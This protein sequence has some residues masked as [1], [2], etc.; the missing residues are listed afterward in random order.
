GL[1]GAESGG[2]TGPLR[3]RMGLHTCEAE[4]RDGDYYG[5]AV[6]RA[7]RLMSAAHGSQVIVSLVAVEPLR[8][9]GAYDF[10]PADLGEIRLRDLA[11]P[12]RVFQLVAPDLEREFPPLRSLD[13]FATNLPTFLSS[14]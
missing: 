9:A 2:A 3:V 8:D 5:S 14:F 10:D 11:R 12:E 1:L 6:N 7:A 4:L 13:A